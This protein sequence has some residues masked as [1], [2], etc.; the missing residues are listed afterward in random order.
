MYRALWWRDR[1]SQPC[2]LAYA[3]VRLVRLMLRGWRGACDRWCGVM[4][5]VGVQVFLRF[6]LKLRERERDI[7][8]IDLT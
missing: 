5:C 3:E 8:R 1:H 7:Q 4:R 6:S 2:A